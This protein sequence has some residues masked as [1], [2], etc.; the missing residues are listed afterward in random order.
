MKVQDKNDQYFG[1]NISRLVK[2]HGG[3]WIIIVHGRKFA[4]VSR[5]RLVETVQK[6]RQKYPGCTPLVSAIPRPSELQCL[7]KF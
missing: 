2:E 3:K 5:A 4:I 6:V 7:L 1:R